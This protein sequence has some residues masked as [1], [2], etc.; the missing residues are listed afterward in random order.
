[1]SYV[2]TERC[3]NCK[4][5]N[6][7][8]VCP[9]QCFHEGPNS[10]AIDPDVCI[11][12]GA[13]EEECPVHAI[14]QEEDLPGE[15]EVSIKLNEELSH[16]WPEIAEAHAALPEADKWKDKDHKLEFLDKGD[17]KSA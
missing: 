4:Y 5:T 7:V 12:C 6:C 1:M 13:C 2:V 10:V 3:V 14:Y 11:D 8:Q 16:Q 15:Y 9:V 17:K